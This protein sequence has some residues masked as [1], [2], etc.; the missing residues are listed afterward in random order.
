MMHHV[1]GRSVLGA[2]EGHKMEPISL[3][4][5]KVVISARL[6]RRP[7]SLRSKHRYTP[8]QERVQ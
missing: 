3:W 2:E 4:Q 8:K 1:W 5:A 6:S 7:S